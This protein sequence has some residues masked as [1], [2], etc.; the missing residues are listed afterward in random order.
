MKPRVLILN[1]PS[2]DKFQYIKE[3]RCES[4]KGGQLTPPVTLGIISALL[5]QNNIDNDLRV[6]TTSNL[7]LSI[8]T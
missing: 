4:R 3:G 8:I 5:S 2:F 7:C 6:M 1:P